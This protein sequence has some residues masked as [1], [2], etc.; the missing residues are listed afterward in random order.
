MAKKRAAGK[1]VA[2]ISGLKPDSTTGALRGR[3]AQ[4]TEGVFNPSAEVSAAV[5]GH[6]PTE[7]NILQKI[8]GALESWGV[9]LTLLLT[10]AGGVGAY[11]VFKKDLEVAG[12]DISELKGKVSDHEGKIVDLK[13]KDVS[14]SKDIET[15]KTELRDV[16]SDLGAIR[17][18]VNKLQS[19]QAVMD[20]R[21]R[22]RPGYVQ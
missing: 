3:N 6:V 22:R 20:D 21:T 14:I 11:Y 8:V 16:K 10:I 5:P 9:I 2:I 13:M 12:S 19:N 4:D 1:R 18:D 7:S 15:N 17:N